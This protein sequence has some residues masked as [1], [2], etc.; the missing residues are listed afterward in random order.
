MKILPK[1]IQPYAVGKNY[2]RSVELSMFHVQCT[3]VGNKG[4]IVLATDSAIYIYLHGH[5]SL[6][7]GHWQD[8]G[9]STNERG[10]DA[11]FTTITGIVF[12][13]E[14]T[15][16]ICEY[17]NPVV[18]RVSL[19]GQVSTIAGSKEQGD[20]DGVGVLARF[21]RPNG[22]DIDSKGMI[23]VC[24]AGN[25]NIRIVHPHTGLVTTVL[26]NDANSVAP[27]SVPGF[28]KNPTSVAVDMNDD[29]IVVD[30]GH[31]CVRKINVASGRMVVIAGNGECGD[32]DGVGEFA[33][34]S[35][36]LRGA[37][38]DGNNNII[39]ADYNNLKI[40]MITKEGMVSTLAGW[41]NPDYEYNDS[42]VWSDNEDEECDGPGV[43]AGIPCPMQVAITQNGEV[44]VLED[45][46]KWLR[47]IDASL[48]PPL[49]VFSEKM[50]E[51]RALRLLQSDMRVLLDNDQTADIVI[52]T[53]FNGN[54]VRFSAHRVILMARS[55]YFQALLS[56]G[57]TNHGEVVLEDVNPTTFSV[58]LRFLYTHEISPL[59]DLPEGVTY[60][61]IMKT[62]DYFDSSALCDICFRKIREY[63]LTAII[64]PDEMVEDRP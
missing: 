10:G 62:A 55:K 6:I 54:T 26:I 19:L 8:T 20:M 42:K 50:L 4:E 29:L 23:Y 32:K 11:R 12:E 5:Y 38:V 59:Q 14:D 18:R 43:V 47:F 63:G 58:F 48:E 64:D 25:D 33:Q 21:N 2:V 39:L 30:M 7:A 31:N 56:F 24:D 3:A 27:V 13:K 17:H 37:V 60:F 53:N 22:I 51:A 36:E 1:H 16:L 46:G 49:R 57:K 35:D 15:L 44:V 40:R 9:F 61:D 41:G 28:L 45:W 52:V 34:F